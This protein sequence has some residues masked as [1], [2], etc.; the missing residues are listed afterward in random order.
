MMP[1][2]NDEK[3]WYALYSKPRWE[4]KL[5]SALLLKGIESYC[6]LNKVVKQWSDRKKVIE[7]PLFRSY[8]FVR[9]LE[10]EKYE[11]LNTPGAIQY[12]YY[13]K[14]PAIIKDCEIE[15]IKNFLNEEGGKVEIIDAHT[16]KENTKVKVRRGVFTDAEGTVLRSGKR[17]VYVMIESLGTVMMVEFK[18][19]H[20]LRI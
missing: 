15:L 16:F 3:K 10:S 12:V 14:K 9:I 5:D 7:E 18:A 2:K 19:E 4:K 6:P 20:L 1:E 13:D 8:V 17:K 11:V